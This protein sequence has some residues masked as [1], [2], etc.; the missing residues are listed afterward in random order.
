MITSMDEP[1]ELLDLTDDQDNII[2]TIHRQ[3][4]LSLEKSRRGFARAVG[5]FLLNE[6]GQLW[7]PRRSKHKMIA[8]GGLD[9]SAGEHVMH[10]E[11]YRAAA[12]RGLREELT[13]HADPGKLFFIGTIPPFPSMPYFHEIFGYPYNKTP[14]FSDKDFTEY[15]WLSPGEVYNRLS[16][17]ESSKEVLLLSIHLVIQYMEKKELPL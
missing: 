4:V 1:E 12:L 16:A 7:I 9:F 10:N 13:I 2:G 6:H 14:T 5:V 17:G 3:E 8:P 11:S 15:E